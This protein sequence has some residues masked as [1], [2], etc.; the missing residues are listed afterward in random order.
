MQ[1][2]AFAASRRGIPVV[3]PSR[4]AADTKPSSD[5]VTASEIA[6]YAYCAKAWHIEHVQHLTPPAETMDR[7]EAGVRAH[8]MH[9]REVELMSTLVRRQLSFVV[10]LLFLAVLA[11][12]I[13][14]LI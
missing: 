5:D 14:V 7:R 1:T 2:L 8:E 12:L 4:A 6:C 13:A 11:A 10:V 3:E 9:G